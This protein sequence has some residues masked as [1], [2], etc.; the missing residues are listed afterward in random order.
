MKDTKPSLLRSI[1]IGLAVVAAI[2]IFAYGFDVAQI[3]FA[4]TREPQRQDSLIRVLRALARP[5]VL[6]YDRAD[7]SV[8]TPIQVPCP[9]GDVT[10]APAS[11]PEGAEPYLV[12]T[13][14]CAD[15]RDEVTVE[16]FNFEPNSR[17]CSPQCRKS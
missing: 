3:N 10:A 6:V 5:D 7:V 1:G 11:A 17:F 14:A 15:P 13:P 12:I 9:A 2:I 4:E 16:G 8:T